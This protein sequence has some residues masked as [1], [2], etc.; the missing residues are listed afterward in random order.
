MSNATAKRTIPVVLALVVLG[1]WAFLDT[2]SN[3]GYAPT[4]PIPFSHLIHAGTNKIPC[5]YCHSNA[6][7]SRYA[8]VPPA[9][10][11]MNCH[12][13]VRTERPTIQQL[14]QLYQA[15][16]SVPWVR[17]HRVPDYVYFS[18]QWHVAK[19]IECQKCHGQVQ[20]M[21]VIRQST[22]LKMGM[23]I[24]C[25]RQEKASVECNTCHV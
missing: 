4:Q 13:V 14:T 21:D 22:S 18:H 9:A 1:G 2:F 19:G 11:C 5:L 16:K 25:H 17:V 24:S 20:N 3:V 12:T 6:E 23:C 8:T 7:R 15:G 10:V